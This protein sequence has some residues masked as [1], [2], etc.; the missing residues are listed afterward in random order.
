MS[1]FTEGWMLSINNK[2]HLTQIWNLVYI[3]MNIFLKGKLKLN[4]ISSVHFGKFGQEQV[5]NLH[6]I[7]A[8]SVGRA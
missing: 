6:N 1:D 5:L 2:I 3:D 7:P 4:V 8:S